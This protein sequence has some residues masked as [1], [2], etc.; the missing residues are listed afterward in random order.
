MSDLEQVTVLVQMYIDG[1]AGD[2]DVLRE[3]FHPTARMIGK[4]EDWESMVDVPI[5]DF[6]DEVAANPDMAGPSYAAR[7]RSIDLTA[8]VGTAVLVE[9]DYLG[10]DFVNYFTVARLDGR[11]RI[12]GK[13]YAHT[14]GS[15]G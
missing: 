15:P 10:C 14:G 3:A 11:W 9:T 8:D 7:I 5:A 6:F 4:L 2:V 1:A 12:T 13:L